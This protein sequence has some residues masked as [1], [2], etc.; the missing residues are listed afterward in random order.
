MK[1]E[2]MVVIYKSKSGFVKKYAEW[3]AQELQCEIKENKKLTL[4]DIKNYD[5]IIYGGGLYAVGVNGIN[6]I[7]DNF[8]SLKEKNLYAFA[9]GATPPR[10]EDIKKVWEKNLTKE[11]R[12]R[13]KTFFFRGGFNYSKL[14]KGDKVM[15]SMMKF[16]LKR[17]KNSTE[18]KKG[19]LELI[20]HPTDFTDIKN[21]EQL[22]S[23]IASKCGGSYE[24]Y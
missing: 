21:I 1:N 16:V 2:K 4:E 8:E 3:I 14:S 12:N 13:I 15:M 10:E 17:D 24:E 22:V 6:L 19:M 20:D 18:D 5:T 7:T 23:Q 9:S 11:Q